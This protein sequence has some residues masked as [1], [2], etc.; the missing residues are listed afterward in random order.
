VGNTSR[1]TWAQQCDLV[2]QAQQY[3]DS[4]LLEIQRLDAGPNCS[5]P[6]G[7]SP[8]VWTIQFD[9]P[10]PAWTDQQLVLASLVG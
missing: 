1:A 8:R 7:C 2:T 9:T 3:L 5:R 10:L 4:K 6:Y